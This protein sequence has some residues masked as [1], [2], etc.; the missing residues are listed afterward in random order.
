MIRRANEKVR[1]NVFRT[2]VRHSIVTPDGEQFRWEEQIYALRISPGKY[3]R[4]ETVVGDLPGL[5]EAL[6]GG[7][8]V[9]YPFA[10]PVALI[11]RAKGKKIGLPPNCALRNDNGIYDIIA[12]DFLVVGVRDGTIGSLLLTMMDKYATVF[13][14]PELFQWYGD[15]SVKVT[16]IPDEIFEDGEILPY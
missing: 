8:E 5:E 15:G 4:V 7:V 10:D 3:P 2:N 13:G 1:K 6:G 14:W 12:G 11:V 9:I 16:Q